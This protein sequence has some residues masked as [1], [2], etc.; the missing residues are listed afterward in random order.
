MSDTSTQGRAALPFRLRLP[1]GQV[2]AARWIGRLRLVPA[3][4]IEE[5]VAVVPPRPDRPDQLPIAVGRDA[6]GR[7]VG[8]ALL[9]SVQRRRMPSERRA[10]LAWLGGAPAATWEHR[11][12]TAGQNA[13]G[14]KS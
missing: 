6:D 9:L 10:A 14:G 7:L 11:P 1:D 2:H 3:D 4:R 5:A 13:A 12:E 8:T